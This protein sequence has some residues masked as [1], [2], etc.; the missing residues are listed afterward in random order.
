VQRRNIIGTVITVLAVGLSVLAGAAPASAAPGDGY[1]WKDVATSRCLDGGLTDD[2]IFTR[3]C[4]SRYTQLWQF[5]TVTGGIHI[6]NDVATRMNNCLTTDNSKVYKVAC[7]FNVTGRSQ[8]WTSIQGSYGRMF[9][10]SLGKCLDSNS[11]GAVYMNTCQS[12]NRYQ[13]WV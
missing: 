9:K 12:S 10:S 11:S 2:T 4:D 7:G 13:N 1:W 8:T 3:A 6:E 5:K